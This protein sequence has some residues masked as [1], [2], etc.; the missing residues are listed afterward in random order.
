[1]DGLR[2]REFLAFCGFFVLVLAGPPLFFFR[3][4]R[5]RPLQPTTLLT[6]T[7][8]NNQ[9]FELRQDNPDRARAVFERYV[10]VLPSVRAW[11]RY[12]KFE[13]S[14]ARPRAARRV[15]ERAAAAL[16]ASADTLEFL[17]KFAQFEE[18][19]REPDRARA[20][21]R[22]GMAVLPRDQARE[23]HEALSRFEKAHGDQRG[24]EDAVLAKRRL[25]YERAVESDPHDYD[26]WFDWVRLEEQAVGAASSAAAAAQATAEEAGE[27]VGGGVGGGPAATAAAAASAAA[28]A[29]V[30]RARDTYER[31]C[32]GALPPSSADKRYWRRYVYLWIK[33][34]LFEELDAGDRDRAR[35]VLRA[36]LKL[37]PHNGGGVGAGGACG[38]FTFAKLWLM[39]AK[40]ELR[41]GRL[42]AARRVLGTALGMCPKP[43]LF[44]GYIELELAMGHVDR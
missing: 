5:S 30:Q 12:A 27:G 31:A 18:M 23:L 13:M 32:A 1:V 41:A 10:E 7:N 25:E 43:K 4:H 6:Q 34:A 40:L 29:A 14:R 42:D 21:Y 3:S 44:K 22:H 20:I 35:E 33:Y 39:A 15:Y 28:A 17:T 26:A 37:V 2:Q 8:N 9:Q 36:A 19:A 24:V 16:G 38:G 11:V